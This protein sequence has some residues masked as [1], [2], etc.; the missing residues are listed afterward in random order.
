M[1]AGE[2]VW[3]LLS[4][5]LAPALFWMGYWRWKDRFRPEPFTALGGTYLLGFAA[6]MLCL[7]AYQASAMIGLPEDPA[8]LAEKSPAAFALYAVFVIGPLEEGVKLIA[9]LAFCLT[10]RELDEPIDGIVYAACLGLGFA[11]YEN[12]FYMEELTGFA[13][14]GR[15]AASPL[16]HTLFASIWGLAIA[17][18]K[19]E[20]RPIVVPA[21]GSFTLAVLAHGIYDALTVHPLLQPVASLVVLAL[22]AWQLVRIRRMQIAGATH[23]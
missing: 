20:G 1:T 18:A 4:C 11:S 23:R 21:L 5:V 14:Y 2:I 7:R 15:A 10:L 9:F 6:G 19:L 22:W 8:S 12:L 13:R 3:V 16:V 17:R